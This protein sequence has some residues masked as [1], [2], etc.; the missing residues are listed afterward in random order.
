MLRVH[1]HESV[2]R[3]ESVSLDDVLSTVLPS[4]A[5]EQGIY[6]SDMDDTMFHGDSGQLV[7]VECLRQPA[8]YEHTDPQE[9][10]QVLLPDTDIGAEYSAREYIERGARGWIDGVSVEQCLSAIQIK[11]TLMED[12][13][14]IQRRIHAGDQD[15]D[16]DVRKFI[17]SAMALDNLLIGL[18]RQHPDQSVS[19]RISTAFS[20]VR[21]FKGQSAARLAHLAVTLLTQHP[22]H[23]ERHYTLGE[24]AERIIDRSVRINASILRVLKQLTMHG[25]DG[26]V[27]TGSPQLVAQSLIAHSPYAR[28][29][30]KEHIQGVKLAQSDE[31]QLTGYIEGQHIFG[32]TKRHILEEIQQKTGKM[33]YMALG[34]FPSSDRHMGAVALENGGVFI[35]T[36]KTGYVEQVR[37]VFDTALKQIMDPHRVERAA[38]RIIYLPGEEKSL[39]EL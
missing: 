14:H 16:S 19:S 36:H 22:E 32:L 29:I 7:F 12:F 1:T 21:L 23:P 13:I 34:D 24:A 8:F 39:S 3:G 11:D 38:D 4:H 30:P 2:G 26:H 20:R 6:A 18:V 25:M 28:I 35:I 9:L 17:T 15:M 33:V 27:I 10:R 37:D 31:G 5:F